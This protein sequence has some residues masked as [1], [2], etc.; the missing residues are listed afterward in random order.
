MPEKSGGGRLLFVSPT[1]TPP[2][3]SAPWSGKRDP[4]FT[5]TK[6]N[7]KRPLSSPKVHGG[8]S[9]SPSLTIV[10]IVC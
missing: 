2:Q 6:S 10:S 8:P 1:V 9:L 3:K 5:I 7:N 4:S